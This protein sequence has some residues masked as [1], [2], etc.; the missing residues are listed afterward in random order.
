VK[1]CISWIFVIATTV[2][3]E[4][5]GQHARTQEGRKRLLT[6]SVCMVLDRTFCVESKSILL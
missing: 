3:G 6:V 1:N 5:A 4:A 2:A